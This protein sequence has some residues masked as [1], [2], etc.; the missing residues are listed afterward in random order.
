MMVG[1][2]TDP[3]HI[4]EYIP[5]CTVIIEFNP[6]NTVQELTRVLKQVPTYCFYNLSDEMY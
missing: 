5:T 6:L 4:T 3:Y 2:R 1:V